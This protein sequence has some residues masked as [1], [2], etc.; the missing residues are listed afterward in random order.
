MNQVG[1]FITLEPFGAGGDA[2]KVILPGLDEN[3]GIL[4]MNRRVANWIEISAWRS[5]GFYRRIGGEELQTK[6]QQNG[7]H[8]ISHIPDTTSK[9]AC[10]KSHSG[11]IPDFG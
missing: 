5:Q 1:R 6:K 4:Q 11:V 8:N 7:S 9:A 3:K 2:E 10:C